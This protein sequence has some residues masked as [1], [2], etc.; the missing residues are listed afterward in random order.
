MSLT[1]S[2]PGLRSGYCVILIEELQA[3]MGYSGMSAL[4]EERIALTRAASMNLFRGVE[5][6]GTA[7]CLLTSQ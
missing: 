2:D 6:D 3:K 4:E 7:D 5:G 1:F